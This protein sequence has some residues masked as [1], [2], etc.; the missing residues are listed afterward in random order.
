MHIS[1]YPFLVFLVLPFT[2]FRSYLNSHPPLGPYWYLTFPAKLLNI[3]LY[4]LRITNNYE[5]RCFTRPPPHT[6]ILSL[7]HL[8]LTTINHVAP[9][10]PSIRNEGYIDSIFPLTYHVPAFTL[11]FLQPN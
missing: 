8:I 4:T 1:Q 11:D 5:R 3:P 6:S 9:K 2:K 7:V 10:T